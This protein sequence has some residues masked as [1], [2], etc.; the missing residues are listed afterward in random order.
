[1]NTQFLSS[2]QKFIRNRLQHSS[3]K[4]LIDKLQYLLLQFGQSNSLEWNDFL[5]I[6]INN[7]IMKFL[8]LILETVYP[9]VTPMF[10]ILSMVVFYDHF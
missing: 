2:K 7:K 6:K 1:M 10:T 9:H 3:S 5:K 4:N 8:W